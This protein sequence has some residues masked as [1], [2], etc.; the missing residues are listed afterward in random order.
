MITPDGTDKHTRTLADF[1]VTN[2]SQ[3]TQNKSTT[4]NGTSTISLHNGPA[5]HIPIS[6]QKSYNNNM[7]KILV[8]PIV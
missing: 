5:V 2:S 1:V 3:D 7:F 4:Y 6:I 8:D